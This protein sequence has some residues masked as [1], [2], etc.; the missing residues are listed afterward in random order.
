MLQQRA[1][2]RFFILNQAKNVFNDGYSSINFFLVV[3]IFEWLLTIVRFDR[4]II[5]AVNCTNDIENFSKHFYLIFFIV[6][7]SI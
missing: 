4:H 1:F 2:C 5:F 7:I 6:I 3:K